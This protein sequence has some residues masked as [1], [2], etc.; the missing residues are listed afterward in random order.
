M[1]RK[2]GWIPELPDARDYKFVRPSLTQL[3]SVDLRKT[4]KLPPIVDQGQLGSCTG[5]SIATAFGFDVLNS[6]SVNKDVWFQPSRLFIYYNERAMEGTINSDAGAQIR[7]GIKSLN[8]WGVPDEK[9]W[10]YDINQ[11]TKKPPNKVYRNA[12]HYKAVV[13]QLLDNTN[14]LALVTALANG[15]PFV[16]GFTV[17]DSFEG[18]D[19]AKT[20]VVP[21]PNMSTENV[22]GGHAV[23]CFGYDMTTDRFIVANSWG[24]GWGDQGF[25]TIPA[26]YLCNKELADDFWVISSIL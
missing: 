17:Y 15:F 20:G 22:L 7:D 10:P 5:N 25:F 14:K 9:N 4:C 12:R 24:T 26:A 16:F 19:V 6:H 2:F 8:Q 1:N 11:F 3:Q 21:M 23:C 18:D 13:Y